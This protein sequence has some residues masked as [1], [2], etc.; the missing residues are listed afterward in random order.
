MSLWCILKNVKITMKIHL[1]G[2]T[3]IEIDQKFILDPECWQCPE[4]MSLSVKG[5]T[6]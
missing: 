4:W 5:L 2:K 1:S 6:L 3:M